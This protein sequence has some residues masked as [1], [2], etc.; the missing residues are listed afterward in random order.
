MKG[1]GENIET[2]KTFSV[3]FEKTNSEKPIS[4]K[5]K[6]IDSYRFI[7]RSLDTLVNNLSELNNNTCNK[8]KERTKSTHYCEFVKI[9][10]NRLMY[11]CLNCRN[12]SLKPLT[13]LI[14]KFQN[15]YKLCNNDHEK[16]ILLL[17]KGIYPY[18]YIDNWNEFDET[19][20]PSK[21]EF[22]SNLNMSNIS[23]KEYDHANKVWNTFNIKKLGEYHDLYVQSDTALL[24]DVFENF[25]NTCLKEYE[26][27]PCYFVSAPGLA[28]DSM[29]KIANVKLELL[30][31]VDM[32]LLIEE[33][34][35]SGISQAIHKYA[36]ANNKYM[37]KFNK[38]IISIFLQYLDANNLYGWAMC[39]NLP[40]GGF[41]WVDV[42]E[43][44]EE[45]I[46]NL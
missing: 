36:T 16:F 14:N 42:K 5:L 10:E 29:L 11:K 24:S 4:Y 23:D 32:L 22:Y 26:L 43:Y 27:E 25:R 6:F 8:Y 12:T 41:K 37:K 38:R 2:Y 3:E 34:A 35:R 30:T 9:H 18:E 45:K 39:K 31:D 15:T 40:I 21:E 1:L 33:G 19:L 46:K 20:L 17:R 7:N 13:E 28:W 44:S